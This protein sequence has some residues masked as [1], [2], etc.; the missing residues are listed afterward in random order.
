[1][2]STQTTPVLEHTR[3]ISRWNT[4]RITPRAPTPFLLALGAS[5][6]AAACGGDVEDTDVTALGASRAPLVAADGA[7]PT[8]AIS[9]GVNLSAVAVWPAA[10]VAA[11]GERAS[12]KASVRN[13]GTVEARN[14]DVRLCRNTS[15]C[16][17]QSIA[18]LPP[19]AER[20]LDF[21]LEATPA[22]A[23]SNPH[24]FELAVDPR[25]RIQ[26]T[27]EDDNFASSNK[28]LLVVDLV[29]LQPALE[30]EHDQVIELDAGRVVRQHTIEYPDG[31]PTKPGT[32]PD[33]IKEPFVPGAEPA[34]RIDPRVLEQDD[35]TEPGARTSYVVKYKHSL[36]MPALPALPD[37]TSR[38][39]ADNIDALT[40]RAGLFEA[41]RRARRQAANPLAN[42]I[43]QAGGRVLEY[44]TLAGSM[45]VEAPKGMLSML[46][47]H[48]LVQHVELVFEDSPPPT[49]ADGRA[50]IDSDPYFNQ[51]A[52]GAGFIALLDTGV[53]NTHT[54]LTSP[55][56]IWFQED[57]VNGDG[58][59]NDTGAAAYDPDDDCWDHGTSTASI[60]IGNSNLGNDYRGVTGGW[61]DSWKVYGG[62][63]VGLNATAVLRGYDQAV[64]WGDQIVVA[65]MQS[66][67]SHTGSIATAADDA[68]EAGT[69]TIAANGNVPAVAL[70]GAPA[71]AHKAI[72]VGSYDVN[73]GADIASQALGPTGDGRIKPD[74][75]APTNTITAST[76]SNTAVNSFSGTSGATP[77]AAG[78]ASL[79]SDWFGLTSATRAN[80]GK[81]YVNLLNGGPLDYGAFNNSE[82]VGKFALPLGG[83]L[84]M[85]SRNITA[86]SNSFVTINVPAGT[87]ELSTAIW[88]PEDATAT[89]RDIDLILQRPNGTTS[90]SS[91]SVPSVFEHVN[92]FAPIVAGSRD[93]RIHG[94]SVPFGVTQTVYFAVHMR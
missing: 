59:C 45:L 49:V 61:L 31:A 8:S 92:V 68:F 15:D 51:G 27:R 39:A 71:N 20:I 90:A 4:A 86:G 2:Q 74:L 16:R 40:R 60:L 83:T 91:L 5:L 64:L 38:F 53:R 69:L 77:Y 81:V 75:E 52:T 37:K 28:P 50:W 23:R 6:S 54:L 88:W 22:L 89:H 66:S 25:D 85:G 36:S 29:A 80:A 42:A 17:E 57:C 14:V 33:P 70:V 72:G 82:G 19:G 12:V 41:A 9:A 84:V 67:Q 24:F 76:S 35:R 79:L 62:G 48:P 18:A 93:V 78:A 26:E 44:Y 65:E 3:S 1:M 30:V 10:A 47:T 87:S 58:S 11:P 34:P 63:C 73:T 13:I 21:S 55:A 43:A 32:F 94:F 7:A 56:H 46:A